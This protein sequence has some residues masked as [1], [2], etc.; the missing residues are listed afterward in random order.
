MTLGVVL[1]AGGR[2]WEK[3]SLLRRAGEHHADATV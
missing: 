2:F 1:R 3:Q